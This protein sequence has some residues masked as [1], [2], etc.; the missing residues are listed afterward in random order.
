MLKMFFNDLFITWVWE[1]WGEKKWMGSGDFWVYFSTIFSSK[2]FLLVFRLMHNR[3]IRIFVIVTDSLERGRCFFFFFFPTGKRGSF[4]RGIVS[5]RRFRYE[6]FV[7][8]VMCS[9]QK[10]SSRLRSGARKKG[11]REIRTSGHGFSFVRFIFFLQL[12]PLFP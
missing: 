9:W 12:F 8:F 6:G 2:S 10:D 4:I 5:G 3:I 11:P 7:I 1:Y